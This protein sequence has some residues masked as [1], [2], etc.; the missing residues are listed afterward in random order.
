[1][2]TK[3]QYRHIVILL[4]DWATWQTKGIQALDYPSET[5][6]SRMRVELAPTKKHRKKR[7]IEY[8][9]MG[10][11]TR[12]TR[13]QTPGYTPNRRMATVHMAIQSVDDTLRRLAQA[14]YIDGLPESALLAHMGMK[15]SKLYEELNNLHAFV[16]GWINAK[17]S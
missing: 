7:F 5:P 13:P 2:R 8:A 17:K 6:E 3:Y 11:E 16:D 4:T 12:S 14:K 15:K 10:K 9:A 1:M